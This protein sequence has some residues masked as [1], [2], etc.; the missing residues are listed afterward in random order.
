MI[1]R[2]LAPCSRV[3]GAHS[4]RIYPRIPIHERLFSYT[5]GGNSRVVPIAQR[6]TIFRHGNGR[7]TR[8]LQLGYIRSYHTQHTLVMGQIWPRGWTTFNLFL[9][10]FPSLCLPFPYSTYC[11]L[12]KETPELPLDTEDFLLRFR[13][14][15][16][17]TR[18]AHETDGFCVCKD[19]YQSHEASFLNA[20]YIWCMLIL[21][22]YKSQESK[23]KTCLE[24]P[25]LAMS[26]MSRID[27]NTLHQLVHL[28]YLTASWKFYLMLT[29]YVKFCCH[30][31]VK[32]QYVW[33]SVQWSQL[34]LY[35]PHM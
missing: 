20:L 24:L 6:E 31:K 30:S 15:I 14:R 26:T 16:E 35:L 19:V 8:I 25:P 21:I 29:M 4:F 22:A 32:R 5:N 23:W 17:T 7:T 11:E 10:L 3:E 12:S 27:A 18:L 13:L 28:L 1:P 33:W 2:L 9:A 34:N